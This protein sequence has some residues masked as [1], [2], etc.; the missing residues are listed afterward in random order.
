MEE[1]KQT[2]T[3]PRREIT[4]LGMFAW[5]YYSL[6]TRCASP[7]LDLVAIDKRAAALVAAWAFVFCVPHTH[8]HIYL[9]YING[10]LHY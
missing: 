4:M 7:R 2:Q 5:G 10:K 9:Q 3:Q 1:Q 8:T 6:I